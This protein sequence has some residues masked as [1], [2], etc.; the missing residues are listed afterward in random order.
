MKM[1]KGLVAAVAVLAIAPLARAGEN[2]DTFTITGTSTVRGWTCQVPVH[3]QRLSAA[4]SAEAVL[5]GTASMMKV[6]IV[7]P[8][9][10]ID[11]DN[12]TMDGHLRKAL[13]AEEHPEVIYELSSYRLASAVDGTSATVAG[14]LSI[15]GETRPIELAVRIASAD[16]TLRVTGER[17]LNM[18]EWGVK[19]PSLMLGAM[20]VGE[21][22]AVGFDITLVP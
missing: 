13:K 14:T 1:R 7:V 18:K 22:V 21:R 10:T 19:P 6:R 15:A 2:G 12:D 11:C 5:A 9:G 4:G 8:V 20:K 3:E 16:G 17:E